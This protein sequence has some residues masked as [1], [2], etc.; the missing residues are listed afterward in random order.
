[1]ENQE[2][3]AVFGDVVREVTRPSVEEVRTFMTMRTDQSDAL[4]V[5]EIQAV[6]RDIAD[7]RRRL[8]RS[9]AVSGGS[10]LSW[11]L[12]GTCAAGDVLLG[13]LLLLN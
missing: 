10:A 5:E 9:S 7:L 1:M 11:V 3:W 13:A 12:A 4:L 2:P 6:R 8:G